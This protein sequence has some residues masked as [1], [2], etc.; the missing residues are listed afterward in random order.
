MLTLFS[1]IEVIAQDQ[2]GNIQ[3]TNVTSVTTELTPGIIAIHEISIPYAV[4]DRV[5]I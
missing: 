1:K 3:Y 5:L 2:N 4:D